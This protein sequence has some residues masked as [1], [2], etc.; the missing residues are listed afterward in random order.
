MS[1][2]EISHTY[3]TL[4]TVSSIIVLSTCIYFQPTVDIFQQN[5]VHLI[6]FP[7]YVWQSSMTGVD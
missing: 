4:I 7:A 6:V 5:S 3:F 2:H 1:F